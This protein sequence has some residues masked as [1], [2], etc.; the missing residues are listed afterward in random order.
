MAIALW[1]S[2]AGVPGLNIWLRQRMLPAFAAIAPRERCH[3]L[4]WLTN[5]CVGSTWGCELKPDF[6]EGEFDGV[7][8]STRL[9]SESPCQ[10]PSPLLVSPHCHNQN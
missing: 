5:D 6:F 4:D 1:A 3:R 2:V 8:R 10:P 7:A 9:P